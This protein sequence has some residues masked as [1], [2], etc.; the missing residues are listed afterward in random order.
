MV[1]EHLDFSQEHHRGGMRKYRLGEWS[2]QEWCDWA[3]SCFRAHGLTR[4]QL[5]GLADQLDVTRNLRQAID[6]LKRAEF[7][8]ALIS[9]GIDTLLYRKI[10]DADELFD[11]IF[12]NRLKFDADDLICG[13]DATAYDFDGKADALELVAKEAGCSLAQSVFVGDGFNDAAVSKRAALSIAYPPVH[14]EQSSVS[15]F[16]VHEDDLMVVADTI[17]SNT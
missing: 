15:T 9:G 14:V 8:I 17:L 6:A 1:W 13:V 12:I 10:P 4:R 2:Y 16:E 11:H 3:V 7:K 5:E